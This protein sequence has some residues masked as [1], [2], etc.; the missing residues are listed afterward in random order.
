MKD[1]ISS[2]PV[3]TKL[4]AIKRKV[5]HIPRIGGCIQFESVMGLSLAEWNL[6][7]C[8]VLSRNWISFCGVQMVT[9]VPVPAIPGCPKMFSLP[10]HFYR[11]IHNVLWLIPFNALLGAYVVL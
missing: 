4:E 7:S 5:S 1:H 6:S 8:K 11:Q 3:K 9:I 10:M 2:E